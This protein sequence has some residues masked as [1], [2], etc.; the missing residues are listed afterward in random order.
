MLTSRFARSGRVE[1]GNWGPTKQ[2]PGRYVS[3]SLCSIATEPVRPLGSA[4]GIQ[5]FTLSSLNST[6]GSIQQ[7]PA[8]TSVPTLLFHSC[9]KKAAN[10]L[11][12]LVAKYF[13]VIDPVYPMIHRGSFLRDYDFFWSLGPTERPSVDGSFVALVFAILAMGT[14]FVTL[15]SS[16]AK[17][18]TAEFYGKIPALVYKVLQLILT[19]LKSFGITPGFKGALL[20]KSSFSTSHSD[21]GSNRLFPHE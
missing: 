8:S 17:E 19:Y 5:S 4:V 16:D 3:S 13:D 9:P 11:S 12:S 20:P 14:Q 10:S 1:R 15:P 6:L 2:R 18:Q 7:T 21:H